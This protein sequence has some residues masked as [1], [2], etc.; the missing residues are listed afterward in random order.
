VGGIS[1]SERVRSMSVG[2]GRVGRVLAVGGLP[3]V[4]RPG[5]ACHQANGRWL[6]GE[7]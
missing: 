3:G 4:E 2:W 6:G 1:G 7:G 5:H